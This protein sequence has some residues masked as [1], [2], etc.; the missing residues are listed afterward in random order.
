[1]RRT[2][3]AGA[4][5]VAWCA[6][7]GAQ[8]M[9]FTPEETGP[10]LTAPDAPPSESL[11][12]GLRLYQA[13]RYPESS[14]QLARVVS[15]QTSDSPSNV[16]R[17]Q[18]FLA[19]ALFH[20]R[21]FRAALALFDE[22]TARGQPHAYFGASLPWLA[23]L[24]TQLPD[25]AGIIELVGR[26]PDDA[27]QTLDT[28]E[29]REVHDHL[30]F[31]A[32]RYAYEHGDFEGALARL[33]RVRPSSEHFAK[34]RF[35]EGITHVRMRRARP[36][37]AA[38]R[39]VLA[40]AERGDV[41]DSSRMRALAWLSL[42]R[43]YYTAA[44]RVNAE[45]GER[46]VDAA[47]LTNAVAAFDRVE[48]SSEYWLDAM[49][50]QSWALFLANQESR[51]MGNA[52]AIFSPYF[53][54]AYYPEALVLKAVIFF[55]ACQVDNA[56]AMVAEFHARYDA[57]RAELGQTLARFEDNEAFFQF[58]LAVRD[59]RAE[60]SSR[61]RG[62]VATA[63]SDRSLL[64]HLEYVRLLDEEEARLERAAPEL[65]DSEV[66]D[67]VRQE[68]LVARAFAI[69]RAGE[70]ARGRFSRLVDELDEHLNQIDTVEL[71][72]Y[73]FRR[74]GLTQQQREDAEAI[75]ERGGLEIE[76]DEEHQIWPFDGEYWRDEVPYYRQ[77]VTS[78]CTR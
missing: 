7:A 18:F 62:I 6:P 2:W 11:A 50:E 20:Q 23:Q 41:P 17:A 57:V 51:A 10:P 38:F 45:T 14:V 66:G 16:E 8:D 12:N 43:V 63:L 1:M 15:G 56:E 47:L 40:A 34:A 71:E 78:I 44:N 22:I 35:F 70:L 68:V 74:D 73:R 30:S 61:V 25:A 39:E 3:I 65:R 31:L 32:G 69:D 19:K 54:D 52:H 21:F 5:W 59:D 33:S 13:E 28:A 64:R 42:G 53:D 75:R 4:L 58:L 76:V 46:E 37:I 72:A 29:S 27:V 9:V 48:P 24:A 49:F 77:A 55:S 60:L 67:R 36:A 26:Y